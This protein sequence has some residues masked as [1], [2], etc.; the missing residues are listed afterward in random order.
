MA[1][2]KL[3]DESVIKVIGTKGEFLSGRYVEKDTTGE[4]NIVSGTFEYDF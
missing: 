4:S 2:P 3:Q 1:L